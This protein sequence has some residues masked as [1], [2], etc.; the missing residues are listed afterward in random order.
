ML[1][2]IIFVNLF[3][4]AFTKEDSCSVQDVYEENSDCSS[5]L[6]LDPKWQK[7]LKEYEAAKDSVNSCTT[8]DSNLHCAYEQTIDDDLGQFTSIT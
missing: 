3:L 5:R 8:P 4:F 2:I 6:T 1:S 7:Y